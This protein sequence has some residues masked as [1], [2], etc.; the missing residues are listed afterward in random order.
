MTL[1]TFK[2]SVWKFLTEVESDG[3]E[4]DC[5]E[6]LSDLGD[7]IDA[8]VI[9]KEEELE[10]CHEWCREYCVAPREMRTGE[11]CSVCQRLGDPSKEVE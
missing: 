6:W 10:P 3:G 9:G 1:N 5:H 4:K 7:F 11:E 8:L 2:D